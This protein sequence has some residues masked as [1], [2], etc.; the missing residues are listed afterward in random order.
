MVEKAVQNALGAIQQAAV[1]GVTTLRP[2]VPLPAGTPPGVAIGVQ[3]VLDH[4][5]DEAKNVGITPAA[6]AGKIVSRIGLAQI[7]ANVAATPALPAGAPV[8]P[9]PP[10]AVPAPAPIAQVVNAGTAP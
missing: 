10:V 6:I 5:G 2:N 3:Y 4:A 8:V 1:T 9:V 7:Q